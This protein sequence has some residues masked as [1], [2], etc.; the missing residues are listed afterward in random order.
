MAPLEDPIPPDVWAEAER[1]DDKLR[2]QET[3]GT[4]IRYQPLP[5]PF[6]G[7]RAFRRLSSQLREH[8]Y[9]SQTLTLWKC[10]QLRL[11][12][13]SAESEGDF[14]VRLQQHVRELR[15]LKVE[16]LRTRYTTKATKLRDRIRSAEERLAREKSE[17][18]Q[19]SR[20]SAVSFGS[21]V[22]GALLGRKLSSRSKAATASSSMKKMQRVADQKEDVAEARRRLAG[23]RRQ[24]QELDRSLQS[25][26]KELEDSHR[27]EAFQL[28][29]LQLPPRK[30]DIEIQQLAVA[31]TPWLID[32]AGAAQPAFSLRG[33]ATELLF[34]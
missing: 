32:S 23:L 18:R 15:D 21:S 26:L 17:Q 11:Y 1:V 6:L 24:L 2:C 27:V 28:E 29:S 5:E 9:R 7:K 12:S 19:A 25:D 22:V 13:D 14:R 30:N 20:D 31:W 10:S 8:L 3:P 34:G 16:K 4:G 33:D